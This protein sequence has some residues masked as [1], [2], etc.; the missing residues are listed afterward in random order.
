M[1]IAGKIDLITNEFCI[2]HRLS[3]TLCR[4]SIVQ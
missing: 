1:V 2:N 4:Y 3:M